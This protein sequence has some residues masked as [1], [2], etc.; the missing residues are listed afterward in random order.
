MFDKILVANRGEI[1][2]RI[3]RTAH[4][5]GIETVAVYSE[6]DRGALHTRMADEAICIGPA[7]PAQS[8]LAIDAV[9][10]A[11]RETGARAVHPGYG[12]L[13][14]NENFARAASG[15]GIVFVGPEPRA[16]AAMGDK[17]T[18]KAIAAEAGVSVIPGHPEPVSDPQRALAIAREIGYPVM[19]KASAGG[20]GKGMRR[21]RDDAECREGFE[22]ARSEARAAFGDDR[23][24]IERFI[25]QPRHV[26]MQVVAD[27]YGNVVSLGERECSIQRRHQKVI[28][29]APS[30]FLDEATRQAMAEQ[31]RALARAVDYRSA[32]TVEFVVD[33]QHRFY[34]LEMNTRIQVEHPVTEEVTGLDLVELMIRVAAGE[35]LPVAQSDVTMHGCA[36]E[37]R[38]YA[39]DPAAGFL[40]SAGRLVRY[41]P[42]RA[43]RKL[44]VDDGV[45]EGATVPVHYDP[46]LAKVIATGATR[47]AAIE[48]LQR[49]LDA[50][51]IRG[52]AHN[53]RFLAAILEHPRFREGRFSTRFVAEEYPAGFRPSHGTSDEPSTLVLVAAYVHARECERYDG[54]GVGARRAARGSPQQ[55]WVVCIDDRRWPVAVR[56]VRGGCDARCGG[57]EVPVRSAWRP[58][59]RLL[60]GAVNGTSV[61][62]QVERRGPRYRLARGA[63]EADV[64]VLTPRAA[65]LAPHV[66]GGPRGGTA[67]YLRAPMPGQLVHLAVGPEEEIRTGQ[68]LAVIEAMKME[69]TLYAETDGRVK[70]TFLSP[71]ALLAVDEVILEFE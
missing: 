3:M 67:R 43:G 65:E 19:L 5:L 17:L 55:H 48:R 16:I 66:H 20:G 29:E 44:R 21:A 6:A 54:A 25:E 7:P 8:Y 60:R 32:G 52:V 63:V 59:E 31:A 35:R 10:R 57:R 69:H 33:A 13:A 49:S 64:T 45:Y 58:G 56:L 39:E 34:F 24:L 4:R 14:E 22:R 42:P 1:A 15:Q 2:C 9:V 40:P 50:F 46:M 11:C 41:R 12:F 37:A 70:A 27:R 28:E 61:C 30:P 53:L 23:I 62:V 18:S 51:Y 26:E 47:A 36:I 71:G 38:V 68:M